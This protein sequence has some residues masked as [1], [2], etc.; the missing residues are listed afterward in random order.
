MDLVDLESVRTREDLAAFALALR[1]GLLADQA[2]WE[3]PTL[4]RFLEALGAWCVDMT[5]YFRNQGVE[6]PDQP[7]LQ[8]DDPLAQP[9]YDSM[10][11]GTVV[12]PW[13]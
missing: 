12:T 10:T 3:N 9:L 7:A 13:R 6:L 5:G 2:E 4:E 8:R 1:Q 11:T